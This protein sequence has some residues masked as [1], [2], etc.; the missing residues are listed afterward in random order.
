MRLPFLATLLLAVS[1][2]N[3]T[4]TTQPAAGEVLRVSGNIAPPE[5]IERNDPKEGPVTHY[6]SGTA[7]VQTAL[8]EGYPPPTPPGA[9]EVKHYPSVRQAIIS[10]EGAARGGFWPLFRH[11]SSR[12][13]AMTAPVVMT[14]DPA[15][16]GDGESSMAFLYRSD[17]L[18]PIGDMEDD[19]VVE[20]TEGGIF[21][22]LGMQGARDDAAD[23]GVARLG[24]WL[25][26]QDGPGKWVQVDGPV[27]VLGYNGPAVRRNLQWWEVQ[28]PIE[29]VKE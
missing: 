15:D 26:Q 9:I 16:G 3:A 4:P 27:R 21:L 10:G 17:D 5:A 8:P 28:I 7:V 11:I 29:W 13:I 20:D 18:G 22:S 24:A 1:S 12:D 19:V 2:A 25:D 14:G 23:V 6:R